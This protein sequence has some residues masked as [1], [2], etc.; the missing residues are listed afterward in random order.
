MVTDINV[1]GA[2]ADSIVGRN[3]FRRLIIHV[4]RG[5]SDGGSAVDPGDYATVPEGVTTSGSGGNVF[6]FDRT[7]SDTGLFPSVPV[8]EETMK[9]YCATR[10][11]LAIFMVTRPIRVGVDAQSA[12][13]RVARKAESAG[14]RAF[15]IPK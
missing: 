2:L 8:D 6:G 14:D 9:K 13:G 4:K 11:G 10:N 15:E 3:S 7:E 5:R 1:F 12:I